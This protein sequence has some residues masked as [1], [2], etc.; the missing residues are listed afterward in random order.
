MLKTW[1]ML[2]QYVCTWR[3]KRNKWLTF[4]W[5]LV[6]MSKK[7]NLSPKMH[8][9]YFS[10]ALLVLLLIIGTTVVIHSGDQSDRCCSLPLLCPNYSVA[11]V[12]SSKE[13]IRAS[14]CPFRRLQCSIGDIRCPSSLLSFRY[15]CLILIRQ[16]SYTEKWKKYFGFQNHECL[17]YLW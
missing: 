14:K 12:P 6:K 4:F 16:F 7:P 3:W 13:Q 2:L 15:L 5:P 1:L 10:T 11:S 8:C 9:E 17:E